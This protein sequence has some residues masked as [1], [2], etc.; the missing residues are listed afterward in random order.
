MTF[1]TVSKIRHIPKELV[2]QMEISEESFLVESPI[3]I[4]LKVSSN[5]YL[6]VLHLIIQTVSEKLLLLAAN[7]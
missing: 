3:L 5:A 4:S 7:F 6:R 1:K 2:M